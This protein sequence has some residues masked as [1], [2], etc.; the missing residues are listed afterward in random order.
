AAVGVG[1]VGL[2][3][4]ASMFGGRFQMLQGVE[5]P[6]QAGLAGVIAGLAAGVLG[7]LLPA[8]RAARIPIATVMRA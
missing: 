5:F 3:L 8:I 6:W 1:I 4:A 2:K 7:G